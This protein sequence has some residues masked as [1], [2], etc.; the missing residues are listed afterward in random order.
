M[1]CPCALSTVPISPRVYVGVLG[2]IRVTPGTLRLPSTPMPPPLGPLPHV[3]SLVAN[4]QMPGVH[5]GSHVTVMG[6][7]RVTV[8]RVPDGSFNQ[9]PV[10][11]DLLTTDAKDSVALL[12]EIASPR[13]ASIPTGSDIHVDRKAGKGIRVSTSHKATL[14]TILRLSPRSRAIYI[15]L[16][17]MS[18]SCESQ[19]ASTPFAG[20][21]SGRND[22]PIRD[23]WIRTP[24]Y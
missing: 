18:I 7:H 23:A 8:Q 9:P 24:P 6:D 14:S 3:A 5:A 22:G 15:T 10:S 13:P 21:I 19:R 16:T 12:C 2:R 17:R 1:P 11:A 4:G 20:P